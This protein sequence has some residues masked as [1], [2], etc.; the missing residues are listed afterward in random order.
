MNREKFKE[1]FLCRSEF[2]LWVAGAIYFTETYY[3][4]H[5][6][7]MGFTIPPKNI[8]ILKL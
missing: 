1:H 4:M 7:T 5:C 6:I 2:L 8:E 3:K